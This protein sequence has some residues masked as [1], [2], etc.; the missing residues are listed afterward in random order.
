MRV[1][2]L[3][4][5]DDGISARAH[6]RIVTSPMKQRH[7]AMRL[8]NYNAENRALIASTIGAMRLPSEPFIITTSPG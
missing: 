4:N 1:I 5:Y 8:K 6:A 2:A 7:V 3:W